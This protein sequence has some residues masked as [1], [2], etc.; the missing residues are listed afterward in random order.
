MPNASKTCKPK[1]FFLRFWQI[2]AWSLVSVVVIITL[3]P[4]PPPAPA[5]LSWDKAQHFLA[6]AGLMWWFRQVFQKRVFWIVFLAVLGV[7]LEFIQ[8]WSGYR[9]FEYG[10]A[11]ANALGVAGGFLMALTPAGRTIAETDKWLQR[12]SRLSEKVD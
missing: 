6:Y 10:D 1:L 3:M 4:K 2:I 9:Y 11:L 5:F 7:S 12:F 8:G